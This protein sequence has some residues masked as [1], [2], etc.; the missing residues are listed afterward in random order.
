M[1][2]SQNIQSALRALLANKMRSILTMLGIAI[3]V[4]AVIGLMALGNGAKA[5]ITD[6]VQGVG[7]NLVSINPGGEAMTMRNPTGGATDYLYLKDYDL[8]VSQMGN[9]ARIAPL[10]R[11]AYPVKYGNETFP[12]SVSGVTEEYFDI[13]GYQVLYG[14]N[15]T[16]SDRDSQSLVAVIGSTVASDLFGTVD[17]IGKAIKINGVRFQVIGELE[18]SSGMMGP[19]S[20]ILIPLETGY[21][22]LFGTAASNNGEKTVSSIT[23][24]VN[25]PENVNNI[26]N[27][28]EYL[29]RREHNIKA[30]EDSNFMIASQSDMLDM[31]SSITSTLTTFLGAIAAISLLVGGI[32]IMNIMLVSVTERTKEIGLRK[33][34]GARKNQIVFQF[35][36]EALTLSILGG[37]FGILFGYGIAG[38]AIALD[39]INAQVTL[40]NVL[41][42]VG[43]SAGIGLF[44]GIYP[45]YR[46]ANLHP[47]EALR[48]E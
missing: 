21:T 9:E 32:G 4:G 18:P 38:V 13:Y 2:L 42:A 29:L 16:K 27:R 15:L 20:T 30:T 17:P 35:L 19:D 23:L 24:S 12:Y 36:V 47:M 43:F 37:F 5:M 41:L 22:K 40:G 45:A 11:S 33:A 10:V 1:L 48:Y 7:S 3:G 26:M 6:Q 25:D 39:L 46:A 14:R 31:L 44:F 8:L 34:V 28:A